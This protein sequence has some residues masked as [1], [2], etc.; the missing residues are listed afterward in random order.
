M[1]GTIATAS[2]RADT[3]TEGTKA[4][5]RVP[6]DDANMIFSFLEWSWVDQTM[7]VGLPGTIAVAITIAEMASEAVMASKRL[8]KLVCMGCSFPPEAAGHPAAAPYLATLVPDCV[9]TVNQ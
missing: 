3:N 7:S 4:R 1:A 8:V 6:V 2:S 5:N 9:I